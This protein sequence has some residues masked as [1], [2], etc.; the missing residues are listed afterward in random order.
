MN[1][2]TTTTVNTTPSNILDVL[3]GNKAVKGE[4]S[5]STKNVLIIC[6]IVLVTVIVGTLIL[7]HIQ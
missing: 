4:V 1:E 5:I 6:G 7:K 3:S 2:T